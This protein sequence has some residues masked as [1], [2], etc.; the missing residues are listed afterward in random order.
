MYVFTDG[1]PNTKGLRAG[2][3][4]RVRLDELFVGELHEDDGD[5]LRRQSLRSSGCARTGTQISD[6][7][8]STDVHHVGAVATAGD[9][10]ATRS[11]RVWP[12]VVEQQAG[13]CDA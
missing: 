3:R 1:P 11:Q 5:A 10:D 4:V 13:A 2:R 7:C 9:A 6:S 12:L 8:G